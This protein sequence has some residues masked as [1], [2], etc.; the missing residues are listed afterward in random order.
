VHVGFARKAVRESFRTGHDSLTEITRNW[1][2]W[3]SNH[4]PDRTLLAS[5]NPGAERKV[6][7]YLQDAWDVTPLR[8]REEIPVPIDIRTNTPGEVGDDRILNAIAVGTRYES[9]AIAVD[10]GTAVT[11]DVVSGDG[12]FEGGVIAPGISISA[13]AL[14]EYTA[15]LP[16]ISPDTATNAFGRDTTSAIRT[17]IY[18]GFTGMVRH[19][20]DQILAELHSPLVIGL[21]GD[22]HLFDSPEDLFDVIDSDLTLKGLLDAGENVQT[23]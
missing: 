5:V 3:S 11:F 18:H 12:A 15:K 6:R 1:S 23:E 22:I 7:T 4:P 9:P 17:G 13:K 21:G 10:C 2:K 14:H 20:L 8:F 16:E 19:I